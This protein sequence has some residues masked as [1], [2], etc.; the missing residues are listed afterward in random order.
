M[1]ILL[2]KTEL[3]LFLDISVV[4][5]TLLIWI[6]ILL[7]TLIKIRIWILLFNLIRIRIL[8]FCTDP[9][10]YRFKE[11][12]YLKPYFLHIFT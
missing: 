5:Q 3:F 9:D 2:L 10:P 1:K 12:M 6:R 7:F 11:V 8:L 4:I